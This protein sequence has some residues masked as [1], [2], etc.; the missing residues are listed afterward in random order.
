[1]LS[2]AVCDTT[3]AAAEFGRHVAMVKAKP[4]L[5][6][7][8]QCVLL[9]RSQVSRPRASRLPLCGTIWLRDA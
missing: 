9:F 7:M 1:M 6:A 5:L 2:G 4:S 8:W 3:D